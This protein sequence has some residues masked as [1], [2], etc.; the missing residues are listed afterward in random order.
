MK[1][2]VDKLSETIGIPKKDEDDKI[3]FGL[4]SNSSVPLL[5]K[6]EQPYG[7]APSLLTHYARPP[8]LSSIRQISRSQA[9]SSSLDIEK[10]LEA[11]ESYSDVELNEAE[12]LDTLAVLNIN[13]K[14]LEN[15]INT[16]KNTKHKPVIQLENV[17]HLPSKN[18]KES[19]LDGNNTDVISFDATKRQMAEKESLHRR[20]DNINTQE[21]DSRTKQSNGLNEMKEKKGQLIKIKEE[22]FLEESNDN[23]T[24]KSSTSATES[25]KS[26]SV[27]EP[28]EK[29]HNIDLN[30]N[31]FKEINASLF[32]DKPSSQQKNKAS[33]EIQE[34]LEETNYSE[35]DFE[36]HSDES[37]DEIEE[38]INEHSE[39]SE[40]SNNLSETESL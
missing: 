10:E 2:E 13:P 34:E 40:D 26:T 5:I 8:T 23:G 19:N 24:E 15:E 29:S 3:D 16:N 21:S 38:D 28:A 35:D 12:I 39:Q 14:V 22:Q 4:G 6:H 30:L 33:D 1:D 37:G 7:E 27:H 32:H 31:K 17:A 20:N 11:L 9:S 18:N 36:Q 25:D